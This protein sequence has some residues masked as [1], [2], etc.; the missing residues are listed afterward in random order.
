MEHIEKKNWV[1]NIHLDKISDRIQLGFFR[2]PCCREF[3]GMYIDEFSKQSG[4]SFKGIKCSKSTC[5][6][7]DL[8]KLENW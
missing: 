8:I 6:F 5:K 3:I 1:R 2:C 4:E 7:F